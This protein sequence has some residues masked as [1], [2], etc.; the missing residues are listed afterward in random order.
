MIKENNYISTDMAK[1]NRVG[2]RD[3]KQFISV[4][5]SDPYL[6]GSES[7]PDPR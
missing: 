3:G 2:E 6:S 1:K 7:V 4:P 5:D